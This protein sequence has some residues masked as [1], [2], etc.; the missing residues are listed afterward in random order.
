MTHHTRR[1]IVTV[2][3]APAAALAAWALVTLL[4]IDLVVSTGDGTVGPADVLTAP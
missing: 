4:G 1:R 2:A 3:L